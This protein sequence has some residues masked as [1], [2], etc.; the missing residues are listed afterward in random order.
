MQEAGVRISRNPE[1]FRKTT[2]L[3]FLPSDFNFVHVK[4]IC[5]MC[6]VKLSVVNNL[7]FS[8]IAVIHNE[9]PFL[10]I[11]MHLRSNKWLLL[12]LWSKRKLH[13]PSMNLI[14]TTFNFRCWRVFNP[15]SLGFA[16]IGGGISV[17]GVSMSPFASPRLAWACSSLFSNLGVD[18]H[19]AVHS[20]SSTALLERNLRSGRFLASWRSRSWQLT[21][22]I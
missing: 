6:I 16:K 14:Q 9:L 20:C 1:F 22:L 3:F 18:P 21:F 5:K 2:S 4:Y 13:F 12:L 17:T 11:Y 19:S 10:L 7:W 15:G 8:A